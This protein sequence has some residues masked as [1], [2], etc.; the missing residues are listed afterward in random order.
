MIET[1]ILIAVVVGLTEAIKQVGLPSKYSPLMSIG[2]GIAFSFL[3]GGDSIQMMIFTGF[4]VGLS[5][6]GL[7]SGTKAVVTK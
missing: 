7:F 2:F 5:A 4:I 1:T 6:S 3:T